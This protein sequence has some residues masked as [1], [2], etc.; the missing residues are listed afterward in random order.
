MLTSALALALILS[1][2]APLARREALLF[3]KCPRQAG[4]YTGSFT[5]QVVLQR[6]FL[7]SDDVR[8]SVEQQLRYLWGHY[9]NDPDA[10]RTMQVSLS[11]EPPEIE[12]VSQRA[13]RYGLDLELAY[14]TRDPRLAIDDPYT[15]RAVARGRV[16]AGDPAVIVDYRIRFKAAICGREQDPPA[17]ARV[18]LPRDP[19]LAYW[20]VS[21]D[22]HRP[23]RYFA[24]RAV[25]NPCAD[26]DW[27][28]LPHPFYYWYDWEPTRHGPDDDGRT[29]DCRQWLHAG[30]DFDFH[31]LKL[32]RTRA[33]SH[34]FSRLRTQ[35]GTGPLT[36]TVLVGAVD[37]AVTSLELPRWQA[38]LG[39]GQGEAL[40]ARTASAR[41]AWEGGP[42]RESGTG[43]YLDL[44]G[45]LAGGLMKVE[46]HAARVEDGYLV[47]EVSGRL[48]RS[49]RPLRVRVWLGMT[50][51]F[52][53]TP[54]RHWRILQKA[55][56]EDQLVVYWGHAG[57]GE[58]F[59]LAQI[60]QHLG[61]G[62]AEMSAQL[63]RAPL[64][65]VAFLSCYSY[66][67]FGQDLLAA[68]AERADG[69]YFVFTGIGKARH[70]AGPLAVLDLVDR[71][72][73]PAN[74]A[75]RIDDLPRLG[76]D[77][78][79]LVKEVAGGAGS[80]AAGISPTKSQRPPQ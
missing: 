69:T 14:P 24:S 12:I 25:T 53:P 51:I 49:G 9:R 44:L 4:E 7:G 65:L 36:A 29:F 52:G 80:G 67:Y 33:A 5:G 8:R 41:K 73:E 35:L 77:E 76:D 75:A 50:D 55:L 30:R 17:A 78:L 28:D 66:M 32:E 23:L 10:H 68:G 72:V 42:P 20:H 11:A 59:R 79:W 19:W 37:H 45:E 18:P 1:Q 22:K 34:D 62:H 63:R 15:R 48:A 71:V 43:A 57:I 60:E 56:V 27:A 2:S 26:D 54:P 31:D 6:D 61:L 39:E 16:R 64:L 21:R 46:R 38:L 70:E 13:G 40:A 47:T 3:A 58:N 74:P